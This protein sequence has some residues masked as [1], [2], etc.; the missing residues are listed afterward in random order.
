MPK[1]NKN[2]ERIEKIIISSSGLV[3]WV[4]DNN[5][6]LAEYEAVELPPHGRLIDADVLRLLYDF[7]A[8]KPVGDMTE[9]EF[10]SLMC[11][12]PVIRQNIDDMPTIIEAEGEDANT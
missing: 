7:N 1:W 8:Y 9:E 12:M 4:D 11:R 5:T 2:L 3:E 10:D 6:L